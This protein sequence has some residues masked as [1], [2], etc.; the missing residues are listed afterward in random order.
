[1]IK[2]KATGP[3]FASVELT[4]DHLSTPS[5]HRRTILA[6]RLVR[7]CG[8]FPATRSVLS[9]PGRLRP[10]LWGFGVV[11][12][13]P[14]LH[15][16]TWKR[17]GQMSDSPDDCGVNAKCRQDNTQELKETSIRL[18]VTGPERKDETADYT[19][20]HRPNQ[21]PVICLLP[22]WVFFPHNSTRR[23]T[24]ITEP[25]RTCDVKTSSSRESA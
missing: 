9:S 1:M 17:Q 22:S 14:Q 5:I 4:T 19:N 24:T 6:Q 3:F 13:V 21:E 20:D 18:P 10:P 7:R 2:I 23:L 25:R 16:H 12:F 8:I 15:Q 11:I